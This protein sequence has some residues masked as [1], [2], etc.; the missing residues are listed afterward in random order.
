MARFTLNETDIVKVSQER[1]EHPSPM[2]Q[3]RMTAL[4]LK[5]IGMTHEQA[6]NGA[7]CS[8]ASVTVWMSQY[9]TKGLDDLRKLPGRLPYSALAAHKDTLESYFRDHP[10]RTIQEAQEKI[11]S[12]TGVRR[13]ATTVRNFLKSIGLSYR[14]T[15]SMPG[16]AD[17]EKQEE[18]KK[19]PGTSSRRGEKWNKRSLLHGC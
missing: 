7:Q 5:H 15:G 1:Y 17:P 11:V 16:K 8:M 2:V 13:N 14:K 9:K 6:A 3:R 19:K 18:F 10:V 4:Y 12:I